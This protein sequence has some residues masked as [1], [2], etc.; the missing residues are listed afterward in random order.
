MLLVGAYW[1][2]RQ[3]TRDAVAARVARFL[4]VIAGLDAVLSRWF[5]KAR[6]RKKAGTPIEP[7]AEAIAA[8]LRVNRRDFGGEAMPELG[9]SLGLWN[10][11]SA[12][13]SVIAG[14]ISVGVPNSIVLTFEESEPLDRDLLRKVLSAAIESFDPDHG[15]VTSSE[16]LAGAKAEDPWQRG[17]LT[18]ARGGPMVER[19]GEQ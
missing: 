11:R 14:A 12:S 17:W 9:F 18:Y 3:E 19:L 10:G 5:L 1:S 15:V 16:T 6:S 4:T 8:M 13:M 2:V 7:R